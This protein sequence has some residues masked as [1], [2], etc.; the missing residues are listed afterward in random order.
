MQARTPQQLGGPAPVRIH[1]VAERAGVS[2]TT[3]SAGA[4]RKP[5]RGSGHP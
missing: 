3:V 1:D 2:L 4:D 5:S